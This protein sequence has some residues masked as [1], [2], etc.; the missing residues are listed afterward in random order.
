MNWIKFDLAPDMLR[1]GFLTSG[2][3]D[4]AFLLEKVSDAM[5]FSQVDCNL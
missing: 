2:V 3:E 4:F 1:E 5:G